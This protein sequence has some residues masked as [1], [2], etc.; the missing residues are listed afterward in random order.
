MAH[1]ETVNSLI[2]LNKQTN[3]LL[4]RVREVVG[5]IRLINRDRVKIRP[6]ST[7]RDYR[8]NT[9]RRWIEPYLESIPYSHISYLPRI[10]PLFLS[11]LGQSIIG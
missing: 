9:R 5:V 1:T 7:L 3:K 10:R 11:K 8:A 4:G 2:E 6:R